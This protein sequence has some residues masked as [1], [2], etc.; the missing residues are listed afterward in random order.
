M[1]V[2]LIL[3][4]LALL[5]IL[6]AAAVAHADDLPEQTILAATE[7]NL[8]P[9]DVQGAANS[10]GVDART[11]LYGT[12]ELQRPEPIIGTALA[13]HRVRLTHY[14][15]AGVTYGGG[16][17]YQGSAACSWNFAM[18]TR[19]RLPNGETFV[20]ND[21]GLLGSSGWVDLWRRPD[22]TRVYGAYVTV[23]VLR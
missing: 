12:G 7:A 3:H 23:E 22:L 11:Y 14:V 8:D 13:I 15:E 16:R 10:T 1:T 4:G 2:R 18:G 20:C 5:V 19:L 17:T 9:V 6:A 21:R